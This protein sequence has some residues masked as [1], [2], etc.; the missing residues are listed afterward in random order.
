MSKTAENI[1]VVVLMVAILAGLIYFVGIERIEDYLSVPFRWKEDEKVTVLP[2]RVE[3]TAEDEVTV[4]F[5]VQ[6]DYFQEL[7]EYEFLVYVEGVK[8]QIQSMYTYN[9]VAPLGTNTEEVVF[10]TK[11]FTY[12]GAEQV[13]QATFDTIRNKNALELD[14]DV[15]PLYLRNEEGVFLKNTGWG[16]IAIILAVSL[17]LFLLGLVEKIPVFLRILLKVCGLPL[18]IALIVMMI[19]A[20]SGKK[21]E[22]EKKRQ[23]Q[24]R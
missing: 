17:V 3:Q 5:A 10:T 23:Q 9:T 13:D 6:N 22:E 11:E 15:K 24:Q 7:K 4:R 8:T 14:V 2:Y 12:G 20:S 18:V 21:K 16:K 19:F 1:I